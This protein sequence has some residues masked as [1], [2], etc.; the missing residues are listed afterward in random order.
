MG[1]CP[2]RHHH[3]CGII[4]TSCKCAWAWE[5]FQKRSRFVFTWSYGHWIALI[6]QHLKCGQKVDKNWKYYFQKCNECL[7]YQPK[8]MISMWFLLHM[9]VYWSFTNLP[10]GRQNALFTQEAQSP[11]STPI[12]LRDDQDAWRAEVSSTLLF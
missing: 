7:E 5:M 10:N 4:Q 2:T 8:S 6:L 11:K 9:Q 3:F 1:R 12:T